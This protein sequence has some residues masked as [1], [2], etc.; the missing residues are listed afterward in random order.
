MLAEHPDHRLIFE[1]AH[2][3]IASI[4]QAAPRQLPG[5]H[6]IAKIRREKPRSPLVLLGHKRLTPRR[7]AVLGCHS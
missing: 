7:L 6:V 4:G 5:E 3:G 2:F 1:T